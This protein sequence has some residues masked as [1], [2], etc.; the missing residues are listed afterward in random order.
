M[1]RGPLN[2]VEFWKSSKENKEHSLGD[3]GTPIQGPRQSTQQLT[4]QARRLHERPSTAEHVLSVT[5][6]SS[7][8]FDILRW[9]NNNF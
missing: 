6:T 4:V 3:E 7:C 1:I 5:A 2:G 9:T 8:I